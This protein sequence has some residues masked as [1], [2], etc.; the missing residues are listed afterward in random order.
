MKKYFVI[1]DIHS[2]Y[3]YMIGALSK[4]GFD[5]SNKDH[6]LIS[7]GD[8]LDRGEQ[9][10]ECLKFINSIPDDRKIL[11]RGNHEDLLEDVFKREEFLYHDL[12]N[13]TLNTVY[14]LAGMDLSLWTKESDLE[15]IK[16]AQENPEYKKY[17]KSLI[18]YYELD[19]FIFVHSWIPKKTDWKAG[20]WEEARWGNPFE[21]WRRGLFP[22]G[23]TI[24]CGHWHTSWAWK[25]IKEKFEE[26]PKMNKELFINSFQPFIDTG[27]I[28]LDS[29]I[30]YSGICNC[31]KIEKN[32]INFIQYLK[33]E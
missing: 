17:K 19:N 33:E 20:D 27:I 12:S 26:W 2:F 31:L 16:L 15:A 5:V 8:L 24:V 22:E 3:D 23:K 13:G 18:D 30:A 28:A 7:C 9:S 21:S 6:I 14:Q 11:I 29:C 4:A 32:N 25:N 10:L 1:T